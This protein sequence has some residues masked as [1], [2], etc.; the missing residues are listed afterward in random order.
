M[1]PFKGGSILIC[2]ANFISLFWPEWRQSATARRISGNLAAH[3][4]FLTLFKTS[5]FP[6][7]ARAQPVSSL[8]PSPCPALPPPSLSVLLQD[9]E[10]KGF[11][12]KLYAIQ[13]VCISV[14]S[15]LDEVASYGERIKK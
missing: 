15:A 4:R 7:D 8:S 14:Q 5:C 1:L 11:M 12:N 3:P 13:D 2:S 6:E 10:R 9:S